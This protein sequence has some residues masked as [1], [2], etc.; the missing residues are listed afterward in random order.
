MRRAGA[1]TGEIANCLNQ[2]G[3]HPP[4]GTDQFSRHVVNS[5]LVRKGLLG[6]GTTPR[7]KP[8]DLHRHE[9]RLKDLS[10]ELRMSSV[11]LRHWY[12]RGWVLGRKS[13]EMN[14]AWILWADEKEL[15]RLRQLRA[16]K[17]GGYNQKRPLEL[18]T[19]RTPTIRTKANCE[20]IAAIRPP[21]GQEQKEN[22]QLGFD[23]RQ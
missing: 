12:R 11:T 14:G 16:W 4:R 20:Y 23:A 17:R 7:I 9:W 13:A 2:E 1:T 8:K 19:P 18:V 5:F 21:D 22:N 3:F 10:R 6:Q 15:A